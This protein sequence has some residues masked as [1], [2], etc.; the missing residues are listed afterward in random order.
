[1]GSLK[2]MIR[3]FSKRLILS[4]TQHLKG[5]ASPDNQNVTKPSRSL[6][7]NKLISINFSRSLDK[8]RL[9]A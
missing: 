7:R 3:L 1:M 6:S 8:R 5:V 2:P 4:M 9:K